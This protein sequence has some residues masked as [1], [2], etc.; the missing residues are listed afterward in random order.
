M[1]VTEILY[2]ILHHKELR[3]II[4]WYA[5]GDVTLQSQSVTNIL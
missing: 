3:A 5:D 1:R 4:Q 2:Y